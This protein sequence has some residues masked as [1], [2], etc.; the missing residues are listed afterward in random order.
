MQGGGG[1]GGGALVYL[2]AISAAEAAAVPIA[3]AERAR[4][5]LFIMGSPKTRVRPNNMFASNLHHASQASCDRITTPKYFRK[6][7]DF[8]QSFDGRARWPPSI[9]CRRHRLG[10]KTRRFCHTVE[11]ALVHGVTC[12]ERCASRATP[13]FR[14]ARRIADEVRPHLFIVIAQRITLIVVVLMVWRRR[15]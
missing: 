11:S 5:I 10:G 4:R 8:I 7:I 6:A 14:S 15:W 9:R 3:S 1:G 2:G 13:R 12:V